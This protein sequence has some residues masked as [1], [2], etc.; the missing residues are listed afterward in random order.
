MFSRRTITN[1]NALKQIFDRFMR[2]RIINWGILTRLKMYN[3]NEK[4]KKY[5]YSRLG[6]IT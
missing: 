3:K 5:T 1:L 2:A 4:Y 6:I